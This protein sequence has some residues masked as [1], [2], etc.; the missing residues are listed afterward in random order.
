MKGSI[1]VEAALVCPLICVVVCAMVGIT[2]FLYKE[3]ADFGT[4]S[5]EQIQQLSWNSQ[6]IR[7]ERIVNQWLME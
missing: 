7:L 2:F 5:V 3:V 4:E 1:T 6:I